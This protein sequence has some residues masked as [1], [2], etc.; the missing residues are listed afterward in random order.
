MHSTLLPTVRCRSL[1]S[2]KEALDTKQDTPPPPDAPEGVRSSGAGD[3]H[4]VEGLFSQALDRL[5][6]S[7]Q[8][9]QQAVAAFDQLL[10]PGVGPQV[11][12]VHRDLHKSEGKAGRLS[13][14]RL[15][16][17]KILV[18]D[19]CAPADAEHGGQLQGAGGQAGV[20]AVRCGCMGCTADS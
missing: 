16:R 20:Q 1:A 7:T 18:L 8:R 9:W 13:P 19:A 10:T 12:K 2:L 15:H 5:N 4:G 11:L 17:L 6:A 14:H 3:G